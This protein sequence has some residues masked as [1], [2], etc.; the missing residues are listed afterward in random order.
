MPGEYLS[1][2]DDDNDTLT[3]SIPPLSINS[4]FFQIDSVNYSNGLAIAALQVRPGA[5]LDRDV[6]LIPSIY[7]R[8][9]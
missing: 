4:N 2:T 6:S 3:F 8:S 7:D 5:R 9:V 1:A